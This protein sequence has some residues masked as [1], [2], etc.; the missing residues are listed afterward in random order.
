MKINTIYNESCL[1]TMSRMK[2][3]SVNLIFTSPPYNMR[4]R[5]RNGKYTTRERAS[6]FSK[7]YKYFSDDMSIEEYFIF[8][9]RVLTEILRISNVCL[10]NFSVVTGSKEAIF[11]LIGEFSEYIKD[12]IVWDKGHGQ[13]A[14]HEGCINRASE[15]ILVLEGKA[16]VGRSLKYFNFKRGTLQDI[17]RIKRQRS[18]SNIHGAVFP[19]ELAKMA[20]LNFSKEGD[21]VYD[22]FI[23]SGTTAAA[24]K[25]LKRKY[26]GSEISSEYCDIA[27]RRLKIIE[28]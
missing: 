4:T 20:I 26:I 15:L 25:K 13:P 27:R 21:L 9:M 23:G 17:W 8:H 18:P 16:S 6:H 5:V 24:A 2:D 7:K 10:W 11:K 22:P 14:M 1:D 28:V 12:I 3:N 19:E